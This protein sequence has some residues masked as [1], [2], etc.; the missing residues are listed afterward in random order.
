M[1]VEN[2]IGEF[3]FVA[4]VAAR[5][6]HEI[7]A[8]KV[9]KLVAPDCRRILI[10]LS[11]GSD[12]T[13]LTVAMSQLAKPMGW[14]VSVCHINHGL[15]GLESD[16]DQEFCT[17]LCADLNLEF[18]V[19]RLDDFGSQQD[20]D[21]AVS[22]NVLRELRYRFLY[23]HARATDCQIIVAG[24]TLDDQT[25]TLLFR[26]F[27]GTSPTGLTGMETRREVVRD[28]NIYLVRPMLTVTKADCQR[29]LA[30]EQIGS[31]FDSSNENLH[32]ARNYIR[33]QL[34]PNIDEKFPGWKNRMERFRSILVEQEDFL[35]SETEKALSTVGGTDSRGEFLR[36]KLFSE[37]HIALKR[38]I[39][40]RMLRARAIEPTFERVENVLTIL[41]G[42]DKALTL[43]VEWEVRIDR[44]KLRWQQIALDETPSDF[45]L[46]QETTINFPEGDAKSRT[47]IVSWLDK[48]L[49]VEK[50][51]PEE[52]KTDGGI[53]A[54]NA[55]EVLV[56]L[57]KAK[58]PLF[59]R[60]RRPG[61]IIQ[62][63]GM[64]KKVRL[65]KY[66]HT[67]EPSPLKY[68]LVLAD[69]DE[70]LWVPGVGI[71]ELL[72]FADGPTHRLSLQ[73]L[74]TSGDSVWA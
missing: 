68:T 32:Y 67:H 12:S 58:R 62:P 48:S 40:A 34:I 56:D 26:L 41:S 6:S 24:H 18:N 51:V 29:F 21:I 72:R 3:E 73:D 71:S 35:V 57:E 55:M 59:L 47:N 60:L 74:T 50:L 9:A 39:I 22:E 27:R 8:L 11:G 1:T 15:R 65:K 4:R 52:L 64:T 20:A 17:S 38:R 31:H 7:S 10:A 63:F 25:E 42:V 13:A 46:R 16:L 2:H 5:L 66:L 33:A 44:D 23:E 19:Y 49:R 69:S 53:P 30:I 28:S 54:P 37:L 70:V 45:L 43:S 61:D 36:I 14:D